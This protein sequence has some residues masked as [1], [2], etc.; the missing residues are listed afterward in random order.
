MIAVFAVDVI[1][2]MMK[3]VS[4]RKKN[5]KKNRQEVRS[6]HDQS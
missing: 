5:E 1:F 4:R 6:H 3:I 2:C